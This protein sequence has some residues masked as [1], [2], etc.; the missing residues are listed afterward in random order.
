MTRRSVISEQ[1]VLKDVA[2]PRLEIRASLVGLLV[3]QRLATPIKRVRAIGAEADSETIATIIGVVVPHS[4]DN[5]SSVPL[6]S[7]TPEQY[8]NCSAVQPMSSPK[9]ESGEGTP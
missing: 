5:G 6:L 1:V 8:S 2:A 9:L 7:S 3:S 4:K